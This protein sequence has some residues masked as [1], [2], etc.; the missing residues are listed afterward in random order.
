MT[1]WFSK[2]LG[3]GVLAQEPLDRVEASFLLAFAK[4]DRPV[5][6]AAFFRHA[7]EGRLHCEVTVYLSPASEVVAR[8]IGAMPCARPA[9]AGLGLL[10]GSEDAW[11]VL[12][13]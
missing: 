9:R 5:E 8:Q 6:M 10:A 3:D 7:S 4:A 1:T 11:D 2:S 13:Q 12:W